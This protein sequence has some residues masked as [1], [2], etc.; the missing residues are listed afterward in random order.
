MA[1][2]DR[3]L[4]LRDRFTLVEWGITV[5]AVAILAKA[6]WVQLVEGKKWQAIASRQQVRMEEL[7]APRGRILD[8]AGTPLVESQQLVTLSI[9]PREVPCPPKG[10]DDRRSKCPARDSL[11]K[12][13]ARLGVPRPDVRK[14]LDTTRRWVNIRGRYPVADAGALLASRGVYPQYEMARVTLASRGV[15]AVVG[16]VADGRGSSGLELSLDSVLQGTSGVRELI[17]TGRGDK[18]GSPDAPVVTPVPGNTVVLSVDYAIQDIAERAL[19]DAIAENGAEGGDVVVLDPRTGSVRALASRGA[20][21][22]APKLT[23]V[24]DVYEPGSTLKPFIAARLRANGRTR[25]DEVLNT[26]NGRWNYGGR[27]LED[28]HK[29]AR[30]SVAEILQESSNIGIVQLRDRLGDKGHYELLRD[31][32]FGAYTGVGYPSESPGLVRPPG[33]WSRQSAASLAMGYELLVT[34]LQV[35]LAYGAI[36]NGGLLLEPTLIERITAPDGRAVWTHTPRTVRRVFPEATAKE[37]LQVLVGTVE[38]GTARDAG[39]SRFRIAGKTGTARRAR[40]GAY[41]PNEYVSSFVGIFPADDPQLVVL[42]KI[43]RPTK[44]IFGGKVAAPVLKAIVEGALASP[45]PGIDRRRLSQ[46]R[47]ASAVPVDSATGVDVGERVA[48]MPV[49]RVRPPI[50]D[51]GDGLVP[52]VIAL[53]SAGGERPVAPSPAR[54]VPDVTGLPLRDA[55]YTLHR[56]GFRVAIDSAAAD[57]TSPVAGSSARAGALVRL[58]RAP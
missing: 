26:Y 14:A 7:P 49:R 8:A 22:V 52:V 23:A 4:A 27:P 21:G 53:A 2:R 31:L 36:A 16:A 30:M 12:R 46:V 5:F 38:A 58:H 20:T 50:T 32:G 11:A 35:A 25:W 47:L 48:S 51:A 9:A 37:L 19:A 34:P 18:L 41:V 42:V 13:L 44:Q 10:D 43:D 39:V 45:S 3:L 57:G 56:A 28:A 29:A 54:A 33:Q 15:R 17:R 55:V 24:T 40:N 6:G 1:L